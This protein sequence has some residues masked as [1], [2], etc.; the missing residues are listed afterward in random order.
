MK[1]VSPVI[2]G[3]NHK[4]IKV[5]EH[6]PE[7]E[8][9]PCIPVNNGNQIVARFKLSEGEIEEIIKT[10]SVYVILSTFG[11]QIQPFFITTEKPNIS[12]PKD[13]FYGKDKRIVRA[14]KN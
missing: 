6:Q 3:K 8:T 13:F 7:Y 9:L 14:P 5:A 4:E 10:K 1:A 2:P 11:K 12:Y